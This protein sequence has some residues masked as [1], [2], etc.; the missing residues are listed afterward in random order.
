MQIPNTITHEQLTNTH[1]DYAY[2]SEWFAF[3]RHAFEGTG[4][5]AKTLNRYTRLQDLTETADLTAYKEGLTTYLDPFVR[6]DPSQFLRRTRSSTYVNLIKH[7]IV[8]PLVG[9]VTEQEPAREDYPP[10]IVE[11]IRSVT[12]EG[13][14]LDMW[15]RTTGLP[16]AMVYG[17]L[18]VLIRTDYHTAETEAER[19][20]MGAKV[21]QMVVIHPDT[22]LDWSHGGDNRI[23]W[24]KY[25]ETIDYSDPIAGHMTIH[26]YHYILPEGWFYVDKEPDKNLAEYNVVAAGLWPLGFER[27]PIVEFK[28]RGGRGIVPDLAVLAVES[29]NKRSELR[30]V[31]R[32]QCFS[33]LTYPGDYDSN[34]LRVGATTCLT[35]PP[36]SSGSP[37]WISPDPAPMEHLRTEVDNVE[38]TMLEIAGTAS[39]VG[40]SPVS[41]TTAEYQMETTSQMLATLASDTSNFEKEAV[42]VAALWM[43][44][45]VDDDLDPSYPKQ[46]SAIGTEKK[47]ANYTAVMDMGSTPT[48]SK[49]LIGDAFNTVYEP[50]LT[51]E[52]KKEIEEELEANATDFADTGTEVADTPEGERV[53]TPGE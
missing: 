14:N 40:K 33:I 28:V 24:M 32:A 1:P 31:E 22:M 38:Q 53:K 12:V 13:K 15:I 50:D 5:F 30:H 11:W 4:G 25:I 19:Q 16:Y 36:E 8:S 43:Q 9:R 42:K 51:P 35:Y 23:E 17:T 20:A 21:A 39:I 49:L 26:R 3:F 47:I 34:A 6:E 41:A 2:L 44:K 18:P 10:H 7:K 27:A 45:P 48:Q 37:A 52:Q 29:F 46:F